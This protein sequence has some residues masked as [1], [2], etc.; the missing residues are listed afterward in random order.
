MG[1]VHWG[2]IE[3]PQCKTPWNFRRLKGFCQYAVETMLS[4]DGLRLA[5]S[6]PGAQ[7]LACGWAS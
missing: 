4:V 1:R 5:N 7:H 6:N 3:M 2:E